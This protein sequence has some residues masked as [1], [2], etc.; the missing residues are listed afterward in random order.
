MDQPNQTAFKSTDDLLPHAAETDGT[1]LSLEAVHLDVRQCKLLWYGDG[2]NTTDMCLNL[3]LVT[4]DGKNYVLLKLGRVILY[5]LGS[6]LL[7]S[8]ENKLFATFMA[9]F[10]AF[11]GMYF[12]YILNKPRLNK[13]TEKRKKKIKKIQSYGRFNALFLRGPL[14]LIVLCNKFLGA[15]SYTKMP[16]GC[17]GQSWH[18]RTCYPR[19]AVDDYFQDYRDPNSGTVVTKLEFNA[20][21]SKKRGPLNVGWVPT[22]QPYTA[23]TKAEVLGTYGPIEEWDMSEVKILSYL[24]WKKETVNANLSNWDVSSVTSMDRTFHNA[25]EF[26]SDLA[27]W[28]VSSVT[29]MQ[30][31]FYETKKFNSDLSNWQVGK[32]T[33]MKKT[34]WGA[35][36]FDS[37]ISKWVVSSVETMYEST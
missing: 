28:V 12:C 15:E 6:L 18:L 23:G 33:T 8:N 4:G 19:K 30:E 13:R 3:N 25:R 24:F 21:Y 17:S 29:N 20:L 37:D 11:M 31:T 2:S 35:K 10:V 7:P 36:L 5:Y 27:N 9:V 26:T 34:F 1:K 16:N 14:V 22:A 32:V